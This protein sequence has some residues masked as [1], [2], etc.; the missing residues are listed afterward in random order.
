MTKFGWELS[1]LGAP[2]QNGFAMVQKA[3]HHDVAAMTDR[4]LR[5]WEK[6][7]FSVNR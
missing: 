5:I 7:V 6:R 1:K 3:E 2:D 4:M